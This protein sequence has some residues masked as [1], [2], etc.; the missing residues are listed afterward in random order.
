LPNI[1][2]AVPVL[3]AVGFMV[4]FAIGGMTGALQAVRP[5]DFVLHNS[6]FFVIWH[7]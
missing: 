4:T 6:L 2:E 7:I 5:A 3:W 1:C